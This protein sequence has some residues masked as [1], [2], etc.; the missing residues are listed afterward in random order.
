[1]L[2]N[3]INLNLNTQINNSA[4][5]IISDNFKNLDKTNKINN[6]TST[7]QLLDLLKNKPFIFDTN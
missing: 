4:Q 5:F 3:Y 7:E 2:I 1:M 6:I